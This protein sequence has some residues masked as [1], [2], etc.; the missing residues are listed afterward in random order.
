MLISSL[1]LSEPCIAHSLGT[2]K[3]WRYAAVMRTWIEEKEQKSGSGAWD[4]PC[5]ETEFKII[6]YN[7]V[8]EKL[9]R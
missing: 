9:D 2:H 4:E 8:V 6:K 3:G 7:Q 1:P 5:G